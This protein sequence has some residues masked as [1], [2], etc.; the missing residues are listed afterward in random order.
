[1]SDP[2]SQPDSLLQ[3]RAFWLG[4][5]GPVISAAIGTGIRIAQAA[6]EGKR[7]S[8]SRMALELPTVAGIG[9][10]AK[11]IAIYMQLPPDV[12]LGIAAYGGWVGPMALVSIFLRNER[13]R[14]H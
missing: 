14:K 11:G 6:V 3:V 10:M 8:L 2:T 13:G 1:M 4:I 5:L 7:W 12:A 9:L